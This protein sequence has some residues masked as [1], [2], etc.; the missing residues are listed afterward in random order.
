MFIREVKKRIKTDGKFYDYIQHRLVESVRTP[1]GPRQRTVLNLGTL[2]IDK[3]KF[4][5]LANTI[6]VIINKQNVLFDEDPEITG[7]GLRDK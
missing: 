5:A 6:E 1:N 2:E 7:L 3:D 4:K